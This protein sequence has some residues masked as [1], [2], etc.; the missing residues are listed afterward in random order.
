M[1]YVNYISIKQKD[2][3]KAKQREINREN[4]QTKSGSLKRSIK[5]TSLYQAKNKWES[6]LTT[7]T[8]N[9]RGAISTD[10]VN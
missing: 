2:L 9:E 8:R 6:M 4:Q 7:D 5:S 10:A 1:V 3:S